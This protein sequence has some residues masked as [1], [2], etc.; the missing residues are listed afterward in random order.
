M[1][2][3][4][5]KY[6]QAA[7]VA[8]LL[9]DVLGRTVWPSRGSGGTPS[10]PVRISTDERSNGVL[11]L[12]P[13]AEMEL[14]KRL[15]STLDVQS[16]KRDGEGGPKLRVY[17]LGRVEPDNSLAEA[18]TL[19]FG[20]REGRFALDRERK[21]LIVQ[22]DEQ[23]LAT[24]EMLL[25][26]LEAAAR[27]APDQGRTKAKP[28]ELQVRVVW[29]VSG[30]F[31]DQQPMP[32][33]DLKEVVGELAKIGIMEPRL[34]AQVIVN[35]AAKAPFEMVGSATLPVMS[36]VMVSGH[37]L[38][39]PEAPP[40]LDISIH[41]REE[42]DGKS[43]T[44]CKLQTQITTPLGHAVVLGATPTYGRTSVFVVQVLPRKPPASAPQR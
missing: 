41:A 12:A 37:V 42:D 31:P 10:Q 26:S 1:Q 28:A 36:Q 5:L 34:A 4:R 35:A 43:T 40:R 14:V 13:S 19:A 29:L 38:D 15:L 25:R 6:V 20:G 27:P 33:E 23:A 21:L 39:A 32:P 16:S 2:L 8:R 44:V 9:N 17:P 3:F 18:L 22:G 24:A 11:V 30:P 7:D